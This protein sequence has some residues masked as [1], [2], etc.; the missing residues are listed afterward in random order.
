M[1]STIKKAA[2]ALATAAALAAGVAVTTGVAQSS[3]RDAP[4]PPPPWVN[5]DG[6]PGEMP[7]SAGVL[8]SNGNVVRDENG[9]PLR[10][11]FGDRG[12]A[13]ATNEGLTVRDGVGSQ[14]VETR[15]FGG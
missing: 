7:E 1:T 3:D 8:D 9:R 4:P 2:G 12:K 13:P 5:P 10:F 11:R 6:S 14:K 15:G